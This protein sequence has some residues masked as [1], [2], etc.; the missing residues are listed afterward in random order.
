M[1]SI[2]YL[3]AE[4]RIPRA[5]Y[6]ITP[7]LPVPPAP[8]LHPGTHQPVGPDDLAPLFPMS[9]ILQEVSNEPRIEIPEEVRQVYAQW[10]PTPLFRAR[11]LEKM[12]DTPARIYYKYEGVSPAGSHKPNTAVAQAYYNKKEGTRRLVTETG[13]GQWG[14]SLAMACAF[15]GIE[16]KVFMVR[17]SY[18]QKPYRRALME[19]FGATVAPSPSRETDSGRAIL[20]EHPHSTG[21]LGIAIS[22][23]VEVAAKDPHS[24]YAL[25]SVLNHVLLHQTVIGLEA[26]EQMEMAGDDPDVIVGCTGGGSNF[27]GLAFPFVGRKIKGK[28]KAR[29][30][31][32]EPAAC[33][34]LTKGRFTYDFGDTAH[35]TPLVKMYTLGSIFVPPG[36]H[37]GGLRYHGMSPLVSHLLD[38]G[39]IEAIAVQQ[40]DA[41]AAGVQFARAEG[42]IPA[43]EANHAVAGA[44]REALRAKQEGAS[45]VILF[46]LC[47]HGHFDMQAYIDYHAGKLQNYD[48]PADEVAMALAGLPAVEV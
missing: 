1:E 44:I 2:K 29:V 7:D 41:F 25:G 16:C 3:L 34:S 40:L 30:V 46:N 13:A 17:V 14:S 8:V 12:L 11:R 26:L 38:L 31:A 28:S 47:G 19:A 45:R 23:A 6:N 33:P 42:I 15:F 24:K 36:I 43:P 18:D 32:V 5:W 21:S 9:V 39:L 48:Y 37:A 35:L 20:A 10:R 27:A 4:D 22:E